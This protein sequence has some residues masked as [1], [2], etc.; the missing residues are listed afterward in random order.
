MKKTENNCNLKQIADILMNAESVLLFTHINMDGDTVGSA[1]ALC[2][3]LRRMGLHAYILIEDEIPSYLDFLNDGYF[4]NDHGIIAEADVCMAVDCSDLTRIEKRKDAFFKGK[5]TV[6]IDHHITNEK[7]AELNYV[8]ENAAASAEIVYRLLVEMG[9]KIDYQIAEALYTGIITDTGNFQY[10]NTTK[11]THL[12]TAALFDT[13]IDHNKISIAIYQNIRP[14]K[15]R[16]TG[17]ALSTMELFC[18][19]KG[20]IAYV[21]GEMLRETGATMDET[22]GIVE[23]LRNI[24]GVEI[25]AFLKEDNGRIKA[26]LRAKTN[27]DV[28]EIAQQFNGGGHKKAAGCSFDCSLEEAKILL[29]AA[30]EKQLKCTEG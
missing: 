11:E 27:G 7:F 2:I 4:T 12:I 26:G 14:E 28:A 9:Q 23:Q 24:M 10:S 30:I 5:H 17:R 8:E 6:C 20:N 18:N 15:V 1:A 25:S 21:T 3:A 16:I 22:D 19:G 29:K 13:G